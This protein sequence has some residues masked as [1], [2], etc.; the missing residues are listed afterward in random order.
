MFSTINKLSGFDYLK[1]LHFGTLKCFSLWPIGSFMFTT[2]E[3]LSFSN[4]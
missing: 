2:I 1:A 3:K 4:Q